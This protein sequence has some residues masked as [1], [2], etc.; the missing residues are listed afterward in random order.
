V[1]ALCKSPPAMSQKQLIEMIDHTYYN[2]TNMIMISFTTLFYKNNLIRTQGS[3][4]AQ[5]LRTIKN[6]PSLSRRTKSQILS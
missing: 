1:F 4:F 6:N 5:N 2:Y 3:F